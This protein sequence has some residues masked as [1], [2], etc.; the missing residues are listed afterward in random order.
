M[1]SAPAACVLTAWGGGHEDFSSRVHSLPPADFSIKVDEHPETLK[2]TPDAHTS[3]CGS[4]GP[5]Y[6]LIFPDVRPGWGRGE[7]AEG[8]QRARSPPSTHTPNLSPSE[9]PCCAC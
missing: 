1:L 2:T 8:A 4:P 6:R 3:V 5:H 9:D 7:E